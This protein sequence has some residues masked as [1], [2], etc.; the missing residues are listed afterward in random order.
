MTCF[1]ASA[2]TNVEP[3]M[4]V[5]HADNR[6]LAEVYEEEAFD[7]PSRPVKQFKFTGGTA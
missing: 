6:A 3:I 2:K 5:I 1:K 7:I 4:L